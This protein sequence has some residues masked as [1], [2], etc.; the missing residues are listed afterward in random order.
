L[1]GPPLSIV[2]YHLD[3]NLWIFAALPLGST[4]AHC[5]ILALCQSPSNWRRTETG[6]MVYL[7]DQKT[8]DFRARAL[9]DGETA[10]HHEQL[11]GL[12]FTQTR[13]ARFGRIAVSARSLGQR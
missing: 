2:K 9:V 6:G 8:A 12:K 13:L 1:E 5:R 7:W 10:K 3:G 11:I 4:C